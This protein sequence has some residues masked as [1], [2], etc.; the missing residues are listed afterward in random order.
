MTITGHTRG[1]KRLCGSHKIC[2]SKLL[3]RP[4]EL[5]SSTYIHTLH[6]RLL[7]NTTSP[8]PVLDGGREGRDVVWASYGML[9]VPKG[10]LGPM[11]SAL[12]PGE[13]NLPVFVVT[14]RLFLYT[15]TV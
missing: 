4:V 1:M 11:G 6:G 3:P 2:R 13:D 10:T 9:M 14:K 8:P 7:E 15:R 5:E 12:P